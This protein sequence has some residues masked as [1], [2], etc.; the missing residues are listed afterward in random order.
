VHFKCENFQKVGAFKF[1]GACNA[2][3]SLSDAEASKGVVTHSSGNHAAAV[4]LAASIRGIPAYVVMPRTAPAPKKLATAGYGA[5][6]TLCEPTLDAREQGVKQIIVQTGA[7]LIHPFNDLRVIAGQSTA[8]QELF[9]E[10]GRHGKVLS[11]LLC[12][13]GGGGLTSGTCLAAHYLSPS[14]K[15]VACEPKGADD[16]WRSMRSGK[17]EPEVKPISTICD[18]LLTCLGTLTFPTLQRYAHDV[19]LATDEEIIAAMKMVWERM[20]IIIEPSSAVCLAALLN[21]SIKGVEGKDVGIILSG[22]NVDL[23]A[24][25]FRPKL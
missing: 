22:G 19:V 5:K 25:P 14:T 2:V 12:P 9:Q 10:M 11:H 18:G 21:G 13:V 4:A 8:A 17:I 3:F 7:T 24:L 23:E 16:A 6:I 1:R 15:V 20:K